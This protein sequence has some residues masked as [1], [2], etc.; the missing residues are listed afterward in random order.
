VKF[1]ASIFG[2]LPLPPKKSMHNW[3]IVA[4]VL[5]ATYEAFCPGHEDAVTTMVVGILVVFFADILF[6]GW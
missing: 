5:T 4:V 6:R 1:L 2:K 3:C